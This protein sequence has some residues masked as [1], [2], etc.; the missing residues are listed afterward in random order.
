[1]TDDGELHGS[2]GAAGADVGGKDRDGHALHKRRF[3]C[4][5]RTGGKNHPHVL[6]DLEIVSCGV[7]S[8]KGMKKDADGESRSRTRVRPPMFDCGRGDTP[9]SFHLAYALD[10]ARNYRPGTIA[11]Q[12]IERSSTRVGFLR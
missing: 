7:R 12:L 8:P 3:A 4:H 11:G 1:R 9:E 10:K 5:V 6:C 2:G